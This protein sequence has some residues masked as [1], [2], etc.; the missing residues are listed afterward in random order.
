ME[1]KKVEKFTNFNYVVLPKSDEKYVDVQ[2]K[3][4]YKGE[5]AI[6][7]VS[8][9]KAPGK[10][11]SYYID[12][13][14]AKMAQYEKRGRLEKIATKS[15]NASKNTF[16]Q[17]HK[18]GVN[19]LLAV[20]GVGAVAGATAAL[21]IHFSPKPDPTAVTEEEIDS[22]LNIPEGEITPVDDILAMDIINS[23]RKNI[24]EFNVNGM[25]VKNLSS[26]PFYTQSS[27]RDNELLNANAMG[28]VSLG[29][30]YNDTTGFYTD[31]IKQN[32]DVF[33]TYFGIEVHKDKKGIPCFVAHAKDTGTQVIAGNE[34]K[35]N[36]TTDQVYVGQYAS[37]YGGY[38]AYVNSELN[39]E[40]VKMLESYQKSPIVDERE[41][42]IEFLNEYELQA[43]NQFAGIDFFPFDV[44]EFFTDAKGTVF[45]VTSNE[46]PFMPIVTY[47][48]EIPT[49]IY[50]EKIW[51]FRQ[52]ATYGWV[53]DSFAVDG[54]SLIRTESPHSNNP[55][56]AIY[57]TMNE[58]GE[59]LDKP[60][61]INKAKGFTKLKYGETT[62]FDTSD[63]E[64]RDNNYIWS[65]ASI[66]F[67][68]KNSSGE[69]I[70]YSNPAA[71]MKDITPYVRADDPTF[72]GY[73]YHGVAEYIDYGDGNYDDFSIS[74]GDECY[75]GLRVD[76]EVVET[77][78]YKDLSSST[79]ELSY[80]EEGDDDRIK[81]TQSSSRYVFDVTLNKDGTV[82]EFTIYQGAK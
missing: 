62:K 7:V 21:V 42:V 36:V 38:R 54:N 63:I 37:E 26:F 14:K 82:K 79:K 9:R 23:A 46:Q 70:D 10:S 28:E 15:I 17:R 55:G 56:V 6:H 33:G 44:P 81:F 29:L 4:K 73:K 20:V 53:L 34:F 69:I 59:K 77:L 35:T 60:F 19:A 24:Q 16:Y 12:K 67:N 68:N 71:M 78:G 74:E 80:I 76:G 65:Y 11:N 31:P 27:Q 30:P 2:V 50:Q 43:I 57:V 48:K 25:E 13:A 5:Q 51:R 18:K 45:C 66:L 58:K 3:F 75:L 22:Y 61:A 32:K 49:T 72:D 1:N 40:G 39:Y 52:D 64:Y 41:E 47:D 8:F